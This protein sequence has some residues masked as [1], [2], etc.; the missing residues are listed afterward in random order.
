M[1]LLPKCQQET[2][3]DMQNINPKVIW[4]GK[5]ARITKES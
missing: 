2:F 5:G 1:Q 3:V 4:K